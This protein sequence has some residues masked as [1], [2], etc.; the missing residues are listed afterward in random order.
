MPTKIKEALL[1][2]PAASVV[3]SFRRNGDLRR[4]VGVFADEADAAAAAVQCRLNCE[5]AYVAT[6]R[7][8]A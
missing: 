8:F 2:N 6:S 4:I 1:S 5:Y 3:C 7:A